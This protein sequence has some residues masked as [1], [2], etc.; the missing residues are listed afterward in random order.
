MAQETS[1]AEST[2]WTIGVVG[3]GTMGRGIAQVAAQYGHDVWLQ[4]VASEI[5]DAAIAQIS[6]FVRRGAEKGRYP[7]AEVE[8]IIRRI[9]TTTDLSDLAAGDF[10]I[11]AVLEDLELKRQVFSRLDTICRPETILATNTSTLSVTAIG[12][13]TQRPQRVVGMHFFNPVPLMPLVEVVWGAATAEATMEETVGLA[14]A[15][16]KTPVVAQ[17][18]PGFI[19]NRVAR[20]FYGEALRLLGE[21]IAD[22]ATIDRIVAE[23]GGFPMGPFKLMDLIG[24]DVNLASTRS[25]YEAFFGDPKYRPHPIQQRMVQA[26][27]LGRKTGRGFYDY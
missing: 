24:I 27:R 18:T 22:H 3:A 21:G 17:D 9:H 12:G 23:A 5:V 6:H 2:K 7:A 26:G 20:P 13:A 14:E 8:A 11:E 16:G 10:I 1:T 4:D 15:W 25:I 19:V